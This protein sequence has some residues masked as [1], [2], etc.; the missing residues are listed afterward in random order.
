[1]ISGLS[2]GN[3]ITTRGIQMANNRK[4]DRVSKQVDKH[5]VEIAL[6]W[7]LYTTMDV[8]DDV[9]IL[10]QMIEIE[11]VVG[12]E[13]INAGKDNHYGLWSY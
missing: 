12:I 6:Y 4:A 3:S 7:Q 1:M 5:R 9:T 8:C 11:D 13:V 10:D 2:Y